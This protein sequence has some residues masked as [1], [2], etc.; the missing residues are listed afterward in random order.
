MFKVALK[1][2]YDMEMGMIPVRRASP[3]RKGKKKKKKGKSK[4]RIEIDGIGKERFALKMFF[5]LMSYQM[6]E[7]EMIFNFLMTQAGVC[8]PLCGGVPR[9]EEMTFMLSEFEESD[10]FHAMLDTMSEEFIACYMFEMLKGIY[11]FERMGIMHRDLK[12]SNFLYSHK[13]RRGYITDYGLAE[14][15]FTYHNYPLNQEEPL[16]RRIYELQ[17]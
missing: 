17:K 9:L 12:P 3:K 6:M 15:V 5:P 10:S 14:I 13:T 1:S 11:M 8:P 2:D 7:M 16:I 4:K